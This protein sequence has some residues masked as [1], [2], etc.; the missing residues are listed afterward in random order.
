[1]QLTSPRYDVDFWNLD[2][3]APREDL[4]GKGEL[5]I[6]AVDG[7]LEEVRRV[8]V[9]YD[10]KEYKESILIL[11]PNWGV[12]QEINP[13][14]DPSESKHARTVLVFRDP[15]SNVT[16]TLDVVDFATFAGSVYLLNRRHQ[17]IHQLNMVNGRL[18]PIRS[19]QIDSEYILDKSEIEVSSQSGQIM[20]YIGP[21]RDGV[22][23]VLKLSTS[24][25]MKILKLK[26]PEGVAA[27]GKALSFCVDELTH[28]LIVADTMQH[29]ILEVDCDTGNAR[30]ICGTGERGETKKQSIA[31]LSRL[32]L[33]RS[34]ALYRP[35]KFVDKG[36][37]ADRSRTFLDFSEDKAHP[38]IIFIA[39]SGNYLVKKLVELNSVVARELSLPRE[40]LVYNFVGS[41]EKQKGDLR[42]AES[43]AK[44][45]LN[46]YSILKPFNVYVSELGDLFV[47]CPSSAFLM[48]LRPATASADRAINEVGSYEEVQST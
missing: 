1:M 42:P 13:L 34:V 37:L 45:N 27:P 28:S 47:V 32:N 38:R 6:L 23:L 4:Q 48:L 46:S 16:N 2:G 25:Q 22:F 9:L 39:D 20:A 5:K 11:R 29:R 7:G 33:P 43:K 14:Q 21:C 31:T 19:W 3:L 18:Q 10:P 44:K 41:G 8:R 35:G 12:V 15:H 36:K 24:L 26:V 17:S 40:P 30:I